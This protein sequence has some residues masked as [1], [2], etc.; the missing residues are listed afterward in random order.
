MCVVLN[1]K[2]EKRK[3]RK[4]ERKEKAHIEATNPKPVVEMGVK[5]RMM[6]NQAELDSPKLSLQHGVCEMVT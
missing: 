4:K 1:V 6:Q 3:K 2:K 5:A